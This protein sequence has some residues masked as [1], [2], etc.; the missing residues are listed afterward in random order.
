MYGSRSRTLLEFR[1]ANS[2]HDSHEDEVGPQPRE[3]YSK[4]EKC[5]E[6]Q[7]K[8]GKKSKKKMEN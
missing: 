7:W 4:K 8:R 1:T 3:D 2:R 6:L 5:S